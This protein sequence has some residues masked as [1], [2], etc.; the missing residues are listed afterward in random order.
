MDVVRLSS[1]SGGDEAYVEVEA[2]VGLIGNE[3]DFV[4]FEMDI[5]FSCVYII[6]K[7]ENLIYI[8]FGLTDCLWFAVY[9]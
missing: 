1:A 4:Q 5:L 8:V 9:G 3:D 7:P 6:S 2:V